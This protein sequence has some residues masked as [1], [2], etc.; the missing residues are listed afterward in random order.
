MTSVRSPLSL[1]CAISARSGFARVEAEILAETGAV[2]GHR[3]RSLE[4]ALADLAAAGEDE[5]EALLQAAA[6]EVWSYFVQ[7]EMC[8]MHDHSGIICEMK[9]PQAVLNR[10]GSVK[11]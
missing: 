8:G 3:G 1:S 6:D 7:R 5:K 2:L 9:I 11:H 4:A 10:M